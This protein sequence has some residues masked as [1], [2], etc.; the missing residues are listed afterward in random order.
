MKKAY[1][2][3]SPK[4][5]PIITQIHQYISIQATILNQ[6][7]KLPE[8]TIFSEC[9]YLNDKFDKWRYFLVEIINPDEAISNFFINIINKPFIVT[10][11]LDNNGITTQ[12]YHIKFLSNDVLLIEFSNIESIQINLKETSLENLKMK[13]KDIIIKTPQYFNNNLIE[14]IYK[15]Y[16]NGIKKYYIKD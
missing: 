8:K 3:I 9:Y 5:T 15:F 11:I 4:I 12:Q 13:L 7:Q 1:W 14:E 6:Y 2:R 10:T 16:T